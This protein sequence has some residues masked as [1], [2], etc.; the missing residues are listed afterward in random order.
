MI[1]APLSMPV[2]RQK[3]VLIFCHT[4]YRK[5]KPKSPIFRTTPTK[6]KKK[7]QFAWI[8]RAAVLWDTVMYFC[9]KFPLI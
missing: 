2:Q 4:F 8:K 9:K 3:A 6:I 5:S 7:R 1:F